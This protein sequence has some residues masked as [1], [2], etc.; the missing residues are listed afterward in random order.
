MK[1]NKF[2]L[3]IA[4]V[5]TFLFSLPPTQTLAQESIIDRLDKSLGVKLPAEYEAKVRDL[6]KN[7]NVFKVKGADDCTA[8]FIE[9][10]MRKDWKIDKQNQLVFLWHC[11]YK[12]I[13]DDDLYNPEDGD[14][15]RLQDFNDR[16]VGMRIRAAGQGYENE[17]VAYMN[18]V[19]EEVQRQSE[20]A[21][22]QSIDKGLES[23]TEFI[24][25]FDKY[26]TSFKD[27]INLD[28]VTQTLSDL[29]QE[30]NTLLNRAEKLRS[31]HQ[32]N[33]Q[34][35]ANEAENL[36][37]AEE[38]LLSD[39]TKQRTD[40][41]KQ[42][43][44][45]IEKNI[46]EIEK[47]INSTAQNSVEAQQYLD[48]AKQRF[49]ETPKAISDSKLTSAEVKLMSTMTLLMNAE[50]E[51]QAAEVKQ[52]AAE[53]KQQAAEYKAK[54]IKS[55]NESL[56]LFKE[57]YLSYKQSPNEEQ[58]RKFKENAQELVPL[59]K[60]YEVDYKK[61]LTPEMLKFYGIE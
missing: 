30:K 40:V 32:S 7:S 55:L 14:S 56:N 49:A 10:W 46:P 51:Q 4:A 17:I 58:L 21:Q 43:Y 3:L 61:T 2:Y 52:Q 48:K 6:L 31:E 44:A 27:V 42:I 9:N 33:Q 23:L 15:N 37:K 26:I 18:K 35:S 53:V 1:T 19:S 45:V 11:I 22:R 41:V 12:K 39:I 28:G 47:S 54:T 8:Q 59:W 34:P 36:K 60:K 16:V 25:Y 13:T 24:N 29:N 57:F 38:Q 5:L 20:D 50:V